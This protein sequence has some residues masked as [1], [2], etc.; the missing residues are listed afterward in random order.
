VD[1]EQLVNDWIRDAYDR[2][3]SD[4]HFE[5]ERGGRL[6]VRMRVDGNLTHIETVPNGNRV[7]SRLKVM[8]DLDVNA[9]DVCL[10]GRIHTKDHG[11]NTP[12]LDL[13]FSSM[14]CLNGEKAVLRLIDNRKL[15]LT[16]DDLGFGKTMLTSY[17][18]LVNTPNGLVLHV[19]PT[20]SGKTTSLYA[21]MKTLK[22]REVNIQTV[23]DPIEYDMGGITQTQVNHEQGL[24]FPTCL[25]A[26]LR[27]DPD[28]LMVGEI[29]DSETAEIASEAAMTGH[30]VLST[31]HTN[32]AVGT[33]VR[34]LDMGMAPYAIAYA[35]RCVVSQRFVRRLCLKCRRKTVP[36]AQTIKLMGG[37]YPVWKAPREGCAS[38]Y[39]TGYKGRVPLFELLPMTSSLQKAVYQSLTPD[40]L[41]AVARKN[42]LV[43]LWQDGISKSIAGI[44][45]IEEVLRV[46][47]GVRDP[48]KSL[49]MSNR[50]PAGARA[51]GARAA[52]R[53]TGGVRRPARR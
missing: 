7:L 25:R 38:C 30:L 23:E 4:M 46:V 52:G 39:R 45:S 27:Q 33:V 36:T 50:R 49:T 43:S 14:P 20:G 47:K 5:P 3:A 37:K 24:D 17:R 10:D 53:A 19:G 2:G 15:D 42:G 31:L 40:E 8:A 48:A 21:L 1:V 26:L 6:R 16:L 12:G 18:R 32:D 35:L 22:R 51:T 29:R 44:T 9:K 34:L 28:I 11:N 41:N 13:R